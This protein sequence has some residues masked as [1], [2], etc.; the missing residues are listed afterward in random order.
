MRRRIAGHV[1]L[2]LAALACV[3]GYMAWVAPIVYAPLGLARFSEAAVRAKV[4]ATAQI[5]LNNPGR[6]DVRLSQQTDDATLKRMQ[7]LFGIQAAAYWAA[8]EVPVHRWIYSVYPAGQ[9]TTWKIFKGAKPPLVVEVGSSGQILAIRAA[10]RKGEPQLRFTPEEARSKAEEALRFAG[11]D[12]GQLTL[13]SSKAGEEEGHQ[14]FDFGWKQPIRGLPGLFYQYSVTLRSG[15]LTSLERRPVF[16]EEQPE[17]LLGGVIVPLLVGASWFFL[18]LVLL[19]LFF[20][21][22]RRDEVDFQHAQRVGLLAAG[23]TFLRFASNPEGGILQT[24]LVAAVVS[25]LSAFFFGLLWG[26]AESFLRQTFQDRLRLIDLLF[27][28]QL[29]VRELGRQLLWAG[30]LSLL[31]LGPIAA[32]FWAGMTWRSLGITLVPAP[33]SLTNLHFPGGLAG[34]ALFGPLP[35]AVVLSALFLGVVYPICRLRFGAWVAGVLFSLLFALAVPW[36]F[37]VGPSVLAYALS[38]MTGALTF[39]VMETSDA[40]AAAAVLV[41]PKVV[42]NLSLLF[43]AQDASIRLQTWLGVAALLLFL[44]ALGY[45]AI[46]GR[47][48]QGIEHYE[49]AYLLRMRERERFAREL[50]IAKG[51][52]ERFLPKETPEIPG[53]AMSG[54]CLPAMEVGG[55]YYDFLP[56]PG[57]KW[58]L[59]LGDVSGKGVRAG[60]YMTLTKGI[61]HAIAYSEGSHTEILRRLNGIF[62]RLSESG[63]FLTLCAVVLDP[64]TRELELISAG[65]NP[66]LLVRGGKVEVLTPRG[67][68]LGVMD[69][70]F[71]MKSLHDVHLA[72]EDGDVLLLY[73]DGV[74]E[75][76]DRE[77]EEFGMERLTASLENHAI[78]RPEEVLKAVLDEVGRFQRGAPQTDDLTM[79][80]LQ[81]H[82]S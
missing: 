55:D 31:L 75:A 49:P 11:V 53:F 71:F 68:I 73:T 33:F 7:D 27:E 28:G 60:F 51:I 10:P 12:V 44:G 35:S 36:F 17:N 30:G 74:T 77:G 2:G 76:M 46:F 64:S 20:Q 15:Y 16:V 23:L 67:L 79:L 13:T 29:N 70:D 43:T 26:V 34:N 1:L 52:Q 80:V 8:R 40:L 50:E 5:L 22:L 69:D 9:W 42:E 54:M 57:G 56:L 25:V 4:M 6:L 62:G 39:L 14:I 24:V 59:L 81:C 61:L 21:K 18:V 37:P 66:P 48:L 72:M 3:A 32:I 38:L 63:I 41:A 65:H 19:F 82:A 78:R 47:P 45:T 58:L